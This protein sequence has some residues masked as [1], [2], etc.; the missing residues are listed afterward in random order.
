M[1]ASQASAASTG[2]SLRPASS[3]SPPLSQRRQ[4]AA[5]A[6][7]LPHPTRPGSPSEVQL[8]RGERARN[9]RA[10]NEWTSGRA[11][12]GAR[13][14][15]ARG[16]GAWGR[17]GGSRRADGG[18]LR[19]PDDEPRAR[20]ERAVQRASGAERPRAPRGAIA[21]CARPFCKHVS[22]SRV[23]RP[24]DRVVDQLHEPPY[25]L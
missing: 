9:E 11:G 15:G 2:R 17:R 16:A 12:A 4:R 5:T 22:A 23:C 18:A 7:L 14:A 24:P 13:R 19:R 20:G 6:S 1:L 3:A 25:M 10:R 8:Q 21:C